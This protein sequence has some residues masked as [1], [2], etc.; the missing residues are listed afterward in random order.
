MWDRSLNVDSFRQLDE[1]KDAWIVGGQNDHE[2]LHFSTLYLDASQERRAPGRLGYSEIV[3]RFAGFGETYF[4]RSAECRTVAE[5]ALAWMLWEPDWMP[6]VLSEVRSRSSR[7]SLWWPDSEE[8]H[9]AFASM[10]T[11]ELAE[12]LRN[13]QRLHRSLYEVARVPE[14]LDRGVRLFTTYLLSL[15]RDYGASDDEAMSTFQSL[16]LRAKGGLLVK[17]SDFIAQQAQIL[18]EQKRHTLWR[19]H[20]EL[21]MLLLPADVRRAIGEYVDRWRHLPYHGYGGR[22]ILSEWEVCAMVVELANSDGHA[23]PPAPI[24]ENSVVNTSLEVR[25]EHRALFDSYVDIGA[26][27]VHR[28]SWQLRNFQY[29]DLALASAATRLDLPEWCVRNVTPA[30]LDSLLRG[31][32]VW[33][34]E[35]EQRQLGCT[36]VVDQAGAR[37]VP[38]AYSD[39][40]AEPKVMSTTPSR[41]EGLAIFPGECEGRARAVTRFQSGSAAQF[42]PGDILVSRSTDPDLIPLMVIAGAVITDEGGVTSHAAIICRELEIPCVVGAEGIWDAIHSVPRPRLRVDARRGI[43]SMCSDD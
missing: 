22:K 7:L 19:E 42:V 10:S 23:T 6:R 8:R 2:D 29:L 5:D 20:P 28:R 12:R 13:H 35:L 21:A 24:M 38:L 36:Y 15:I 41:F 9:R 43:V 26:A 4:L 32:L 17:D 40:L 31:S 3:A 14:V 30:E 34:D 25:P 33:S 39:A 11:A 1:E 18:C 16:T 37:V 27:K